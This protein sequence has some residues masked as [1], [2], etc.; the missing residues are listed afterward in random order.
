MVAISNGI[1]K[2]IFSFSLSHLN[3]TDRLKTNSGIEDCVQ[4]FFDRIETFFR[5]LYANASMFIKACWNIKMCSL[6]QAEKDMDTIKR[7]GIFVRNR[8]DADF[9]PHARLLFMALTPA[10]QNLFC[11]VDYTFCEQLDH[12]VCAER[13]R[14]M[15]AEICREC[16]QIVYYHSLLL[17]IHMLYNKVMGIQITHS[18]EEDGDFS[19]DTPIASRAMDPVPVTEGVKLEIPGTVPYK[20]NA[21]PEAVRK[22]ANEIKDLIIQFDALPEHVKP[23]VPDYFR[24]PLLLSD[25]MTIPIFDESHP[26]V[27]KG[28]PALRDAIDSNTHVADALLRTHRNLRHTAEKDSLE[29][30]FAAQTASWNPVQCPICRHPG[31]RDSVSRDNLRIDV[32]LQ[33]KILEFLKGAVT[34]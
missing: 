12:E 28:L 17:P 10:A 8:S 18:T 27:Q 23:E 4:P 32:Q 1:S 14:E 3:T 15:R 31:D 30:H 11:K 5:N 33:D 13:V 24:D 20:E 22:K 9:I 19:P 26:D 6:E 25:F 16:D 7:L 34:P 21:I 2:S 29:A